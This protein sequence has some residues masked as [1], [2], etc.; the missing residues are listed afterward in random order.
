MSATSTVEAPLALATESEE[1]SGGKKK[2]LLI[3]VAVLAIAAGA[4]LF[5]KP[6]QAAESAPAEPVPGAVV[7]VGQMTINLADPGRY[8][9]VSFSVVLVEGAAP[10]AVTAKFPLLKEAVLFEV[11]NVAAA[12]LRAPGGLDAIAERLSAK[13]R[14]L[15]EDGNVLR[16]V[17]TEMLVQ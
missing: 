12:D 9:R 17:L 6:G 5:L 15:Y 4:F 11:S 2:K 16:V 14:E 8:A 13:A 3:V 7:E 10:E 1:K